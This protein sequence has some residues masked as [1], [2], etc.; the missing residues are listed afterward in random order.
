MMY[1]LKLWKEKRKAEETRMIPDTRE[2]ILH[3]LNAN[4]YK[5][6]QFRALALADNYHDT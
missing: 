4:F 5:V 1:S 3:Q 6:R 2:V